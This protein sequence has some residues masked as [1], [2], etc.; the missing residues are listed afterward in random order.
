MNSSSKYNPN[1]YRVNKTALH[2]FYGKCSQ[3][4]MSTIYEDEEYKNHKN[5]CTPPQYSNQDSSLMQAELQ[6]CKSGFQELAPSFGPP[7]PP[8]KFTSYPVR[9]TFENRQKW[10]DVF[11]SPFQASKNETKNISPTMPA[12]I[13]SLPVNHELLQPQLL[14]GRL[15]SNGE[16][17]YA[18]RFVGLN[19]MFNED[20]GPI[21]VGPPPSMAN[22]H[23]GSYS[24]ELFKTQHHNA[25]NK[26]STG[27][28][29][30]PYTGEVSETFE[31]AMPPPNT[32]KSI[33]ADRFDMTNPKLLAMQ[34]GID[35]NRL[36]PK[37][38]EICQ[39]LPGED[40]GA[41]VW[42]DQLYAEARGQRMREFAE[43]GV[44]HNRNGDLPEPNS[45][46]GE[47]PAGF[48]G[49]HSYL[50]AIPYLPPKN[51]YDIKGYLPIA[52]PAMPEGTSV[53]SEVFVKKPDLSTCVYQH[54]PG[55]LNDIDARYIVSD[56][57]PR[58][59][60]RGYSNGGQSLG[61]AHLD[62]THQGIG[63]QDTTPRDTLKIQMEN[64]HL[65][66]NI[67]PTWNY[68]GFTPQDTTPRD[69]L[70]MQMENPT[71]KS[72]M[73][74]TWNYAGF[75]P[76][77][78]TPRNTLKMQMENPTL[79]SNFAP[80]NAYTS[81]VLQDTTPKDTLKMQME[82]PFPTFNLGLANGQGEANYVVTDT[83]PKDT[84]KMQMEA[85]YDPFGLDGEDMG[86]WIPFQ[87]ERRQTGRE[88]YEKL[89]NFARPLDYNVG[90]N[91][92][93]GLITSKQHRGTM[94][95]DWVA[96][97]KI[98]D[99][100]GDSN[101]YWI[102]EPTR[103]TKKQFLPY[104]PASDLSLYENT[105]DRTAGAVGLPCNLDI[106]EM[107]DEFLWAHGFQYPSTQMEQF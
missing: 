44:W 87:G 69:T 22:K 57:N 33:Q 59:T 78:T 62:Y 14:G 89:P 12:N 10:N 104:T 34:G 15:P 16:G 47:K 27:I 100:A 32:D 48:V 74:P 54:G 84:L 7:G 19:R 82:D 93:P 99:A 97:S 91:V 8:N 2:P 55:A 28:M 92:G 107:D 23:L 106:H 66:S 9:A 46:V 105:S 71:L 52:S 51:T 24:D 1:K 18:N 40:H 103:M 58:P 94:A 26:I 43:M 38:T 39:V 95:T 50:R 81:Y 65:K 76:Q 45:L 102:S 96:L 83:T 49:L 5:V 67:M 75:T 36:P 29:I 42:G 61:P 85:A 90:N 35:L 41:N 70:K 72:N 63:I 68:A 79:K 6:K 53:K 98:P 88:F 77:D 86:S 25:E 60:W 101:E 17:V 11:A 80:V 20:Q 3:G 56:I 31:D 21:M 73:V 4:T 64:P 13:P 37:K 30:N